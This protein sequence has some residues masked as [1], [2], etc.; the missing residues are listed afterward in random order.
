MKPTPSRE[1]EEQPGVPGF[2]SWRALYAFVFAV[3]VAC[4]IAL[5][6]FSQ[7]FR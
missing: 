4:V 3:F 6:V 7:V 5:A 2:R 1:P